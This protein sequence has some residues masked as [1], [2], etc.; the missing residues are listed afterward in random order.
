M[1]VSYLNDEFF[2]AK[3]LETPTV[4]G[5]KILF[6]AATSHELKIIRKQVELHKKSSVQYLFFS[7][8]I[9]NI[10]TTYTLSVYLTEHPDIDFVCN[11]GICGYLTEHPPVIQIA[12]TVLV[13][14]G[15]ECI[16]PVFFSF[17]PLV[18][19]ESHDTPVLE[20]SLVTEPY[21]DMESYGVAY[22]AEKQQIPHLILKVP[23]DQIGSMATR[24]FDVEIAMRS[25]ETNIGY[26]T[27]IDTLVDYIARIPERQDWSHVREHFRLTFIEFEN[28]K[29]DIARYEALTTRDF[30]SFFSEHKNLSKKEFLTQLHTTN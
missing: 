4:H 10:A 30:R 15:R 1:E 13:S 14:S 8:G 20:S 25:L 2:L 11:I 16:V 22:V 17:A 6:V 9:G 26:P 12:R 27:L 5:M 19:I 21:V 18:S 7:T 24:E 3:V 29:K 23:Y 28:L